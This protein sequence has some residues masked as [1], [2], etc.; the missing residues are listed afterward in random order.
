M[1]LFHV[2]VFSLLCTMIRRGKFLKLE[3][4]ARGLEQSN[5]NVFDLF[6]PVAKLPTLRTFLSICNQRNYFI[7]QMDVNDLFLNGHLQNKVFM[8]IPEGRG[9]VKRKNSVL[10]LK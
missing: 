6:S 4:V 2:D 8:Q 1:K 5:V 7:H 9:N 3:L 10:L